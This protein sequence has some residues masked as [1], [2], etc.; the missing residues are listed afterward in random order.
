MKLKVV[1]FV[2]VPLLAFFLLYAAEDVPGVKPAGHV[3]LASGYVRTATAVGMHA[4]SY[5]S[6]KAAV[7]Y[8]Q[9]KR[10]IMETGERRL[11]HLGG[12][13]TTDYTSDLMAL[14]TGDNRE[15]AVRGFAN[16]GGATVQELL[17]SSTSVS[18]AGCV[19]DGGTGGQC[20]EFVSRFLQYHDWTGSSGY[21]FWAM[22][23]TVAEDM[24]TAH[25]R[26]S[27][28]NTGCESLAAAA[29]LE[30][31]MA[32]AI[33]GLSL[34]MPGTFN[35]L[36][37]ADCTYPG[38]TPV[39]GT[40]LCSLVS[41]DPATWPPAGCALDLKFGAATGVLE[42]LAGGSYNARTCLEYGCD[43]CILS[44]SVSGNRDDG[45]PCNS[46]D[47]VFC[48]MYAP[49]MFIPNPRVATFTSPKPAVAGAQPGLNSMC[50]KADCHPLNGGT[51]CPADV[52]RDNVG[53]G[54]AGGGNGGS[55]NIGGGNGGVMPPAPPAMPPAPAT[56]P[57]PPA[58]P[59]NTASNDNTT[60]VILA[61]V[62]PLLCIALS[63]AG[64][65][66]MK[67]RRRTKVVNHA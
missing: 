29:V 2:L 58:T 23:F 53:G 59:A 5:P 28:R 27:M 39:P 67:K 12:L 22:V 38:E 14:C 55:G 46:Q 3:L 64:Y 17:N 20:A 11:S 51:G 61:V 1:A 21:Q 16:L 30:E 15:G 42:P 36:E 50:E 48:T 35:Q 19:C 60:V 65:F 4:F 63:M 24:V 43:T 25:G 57:A 44:G 40:P 37:N 33:W 18:L 8:Y 13:S 31:V 41:Y 26:N 45:Y 7:W 9:W 47:C 54:N 62:L 10:K 49:C 56:P 66:L 52:G 34:A 32:K 6:Y